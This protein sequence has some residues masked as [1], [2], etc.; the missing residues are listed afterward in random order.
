MNDRQLKYILTIME[1]GNITSA[2]QKLYISQP[3]LSSLLAHVEEELGAKIFNRDVSPM[4]LTYAGEYY[5][6]A[7]KDILSTLRDLQN[8][9]NDIQDYRK[10]RLLVGC[11]PQLSSLLLPSILPKFMEENPGIQ[12]KLFEE[13]NSD[14]EKLLISGNLDLAIN[15]TRIENK[16]LETVSLY[17]E[18]ILLLTPESFSPATVT[19]AEGHSFPLIDISCME[20]KPFVLF[21]TG[22]FLRK[23][24]DQIFSDFG[25]TPNMIL[26]TS[27]WETCYRM[28]E[29]GLAFTILPYSPLKRGP[30]NDHVNRYSID[31]NYFRNVT[32]CYHKN[33]YHPKIMEKFIDVTRTVL[34][35]SPLDNLN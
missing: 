12:I 20:G 29:E 26:E 7:A 25:I 3:S 1:E 30:E 5:A 10:G 16:V 22:R 11:S 34:K 9:I 23:I 2:A 17:N 35:E 27:N 6:D 21:K 24:S 4:A 31:G 14:L 13:T 32:I 15:T 28:V 19:Q 33:S 8:K 18:E